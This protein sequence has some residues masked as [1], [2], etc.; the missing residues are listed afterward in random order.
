MFDRSAGGKEV[1]FGP[2]DDIINAASLGS[3]FTE[4]SAP[5]S[6]IASVL[7]QHM[8]MTKNWLK[9]AARSYLKHKSL[10][11]VTLH[12]DQEELLKQWANNPYDE[13]SMVHH[14]AAPPGCG[15]TMMFAVCAWALAKYFA[16]QNVQDK[17]VYLIAPQK[18]LVSEIL[19]IFY[20]FFGKDADFLKIIA[21]LGMTPAGEG[22]HE[23]HMNKLIRM[24]FPENMRRLDDLR[25]AA[26]NACKAWSEL[27]EWEAEMGEA[28]NRLAQAKIDLKNHFLATT[29]FWKSEA[30]AK[31]IENV[32][33]DCRVVL[34]TAGYKL[35]TAAG[36]T[37][38]LSKISKDKTSAIVMSDEADLLNLGVAVASVAGDCQL[39]LAWDKTQKLMSTKNI[40]QSRSAFETAKNQDTGEW[41]MEIAET[42]ELQKTSRFGA[43]G[44]NIMKAVCPE[45]YNKLEARDG[46][47]NT[48]V[49]AVFFDKVPW[50]SCGS[51]NVAGAI[52][53]WKVFGKIAE[54]VQI[55]AI[56]NQQKVSVVC[57]Y[58]AFREVLRGFL[59]YFFGNELSI[60]SKVSAHD[61]DNVVTVLSARQVRGSSR[62]VVISALF[63]RSHTDDDYDAQSKDQGK[64]SVLCSR[65][66]KHGIYLLEYWHKRSEATDAIARLSNH[67]YE[68]RDTDGHSVT[69]ETCSVENGAKP[70]RAAC[71]WIEAGHH[72][73]V[74]Y[75]FTEDDDAPIDIQRYFN[76][77][78][79][80]SKLSDAALHPGDQLVYSSCDDA[81]YWKS[82]YEVAEDL[83]NKPLSECVY[84]VTVQGYID[85]GKRSVVNEEDYEAPDLQI[86]STA[87]CAPGEPDAADLRDSHALNS[88]SLAHK[89]FNEVVF[90][91]WEWAASPLQLDNYVIAK[92]CKL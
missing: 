88:C 42:S 47:P 12:A 60:T 64:V 78:Q 20:N 63:R 68:Q 22:R 32:N 2:E 14:M 36:H 17:L 8:M 67:L 21:P 80:M 26:T 1:D 15:K 35:K 39:L 59:I 74:E 33:K 83:A 13:A 45:N 87:G 23:V 72:R 5:R 77:Q 49:E 84:A 62:D 86:P 40:Q 58:A 71:A 82:V 44:V 38:E 52:C 48:I 91:L 65:E 92:H 81:P 73:S 28:E 46:T 41:F 31:F 11:P 90:C 3:A 61:G 7:T 30:V 24:N 70:Y 89:H 27:H 51:N 85:T 43:A 19:D 4:A 79:E 55:H 18:H 10:C 9:L 50:E 16:E 56:Q 29:D 53:H 34:C 37:T 25:D 6:V 69:Y 54:F 66:R 75:N 76:S 57:V